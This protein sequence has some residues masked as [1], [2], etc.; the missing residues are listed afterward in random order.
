MTA[1]EIE[2]YAQLIGGKQ[3]QALS[4]KSLPMID[5]CSGETFARIAAGG[6]EDIDVAVRA[7]Q[8]ALD[9]EWGRTPPVERSRILRHGFGQLRGGADVRPHRAIARPVRVS[10]LFIEMIV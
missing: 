7:A 4:G 5:P 1:A 2:S 10:P 3:V 8:T 6:A 9:G